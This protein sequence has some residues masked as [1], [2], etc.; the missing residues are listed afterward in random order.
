MWFLRVEERQTP[1][2]GMSQKPIGPRL[3]ETTFLRLSTSIHS[4]T[5][6]VKGK[7]YAFARAPR[8]LIHIF[9]K[10]PAVS[11]LVISSSPPETPSRQL[12]PVTIETVEQEQML[13]T[14]PLFT[15]KLPW[16]GSESR[17]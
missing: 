4:F 15:N 2:P 11:L 17:H 13:V 3:D 10:I 16:T 5:F 6:E 7:V 9:T 8:W 14:P 1:V 12:A